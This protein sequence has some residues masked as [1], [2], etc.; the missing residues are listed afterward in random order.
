MGTSIRRIRAERGTSLAELSRMSGVAKATLVAL[1]AGR[2]NPT[3]ETLWAIAEAL[4]VPFG[5]LVNE[6]ATRDDDAYVVQGAAMIDSPTVRVEL[7]KRITRGGTIELYAMS[8]PPGEARRASG[9]GRG[10]REH[11]IVISGNGR[12]GPATS[13]LEVSRGDFAHFPADGSHVYLS[14]GPDPLL[15]QVAVD[16]PP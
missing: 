13:P 3:V 12:L 9:H 1:E 11:V 14:S 5:E 15:L 2:G 4:T 7:L 10:V 8:V 16:Y 6:P